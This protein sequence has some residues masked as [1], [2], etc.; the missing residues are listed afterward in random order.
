MKDETEYQQLRS[1]YNNTYYV[2]GQQSK[3]RASWHDRVMVD[4]MGCLKGKQV[5]DVACGLGGWLWI[6]RSKGAEVS[7][8]D[9]SERAIECC[10]SRFPDGEFK[11]GAAETL[12]FPDSRFDVIT[13][14]GS[15]EHFVDKKAALEEMVRVAKPGAKFLILVPNAGFLALRL[16]L[17]SGTW[18]SQ[19]RED[20]LSLKEWD[21]L[22]R[23]AGLR[24]DQ[25]WRDLH[26]VDLQWIARARWTAWPLRLA[27]ALALPL[28]PLSLQYQ[29]HH[30]C[31]VAD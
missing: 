16:G 5:L 28:L 18:Q 23:S 31:R 9:I 25:R 6:L 15:I 14:M 20:V 1:F 22:F 12:P 13:C 3:Y 7:G 2:D 11:V 8:I 21:L 17:Y 26:T 27:Q 19:V 4:R 30:F 29:V 10:R 24:V